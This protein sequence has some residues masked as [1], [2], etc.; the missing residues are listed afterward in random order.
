MDH[1]LKTF[2]RALSR[3]AVGKSLFQLQIMA[4]SSASVQL[5]F[6]NLCVLIP[7]DFK[8]H[9]Y[10]VR[11]YKGDAGMSF[12]V[13]YKDSSQNR[14]K[15]IL[16]LNDC[17]IT[18]AGN[19]VIQLKTA[20]KTILLQMTTIEKMQLWKNT[21]EERVNHIQNTKL[22]STSLSSSLNR[23]CLRQSKIQPQSKTIEQ[24]TDLFS[25]HITI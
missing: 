17:I 15:D 20:E 18:T 13:L 23:Y 7:G 3:N 2:R 8:E 16:W 12:I 10:F 25:P 5:L 9:R 22:L 19:K 6:D 14:P 4:I 11:L 24:F 21:I 1:T